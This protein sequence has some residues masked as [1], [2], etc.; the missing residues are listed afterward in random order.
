MLQ[1]TIV[2]DLDGT[3]ADTS[4]DLLAAANTALDRGGYEPSLTAA[5]HGRLAMRGA[6]AMLGAA[7]G[8]KHPDLD[9]LYPALIEAYA[10]RDH[11]DSRLYPGVERVI[12]RMAADGARMAVC[13][14]KRAD[15]AQQVL[16]KLG[17]RDHFRALIGRDSL[18]VCKPDPEPLREA[19]RRAGGD[20]AHAVMIGDTNTD[21]QA[22]RA[23]GVPCILVPFGAEVD[24]AALQPDM[25]M[26]H[27]DDL[28]GLLALLG[29]A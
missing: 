3:L 7:L 11:A 26:D 4:A 29:P 9:R 16:E 14:N 28:P 18:A 8:P 10:E 22:A 20:P 6:V 24:V 21:L 1:R 15:L 12:G 27:F 23:A 25:V 17:L 2:F 5:Q 19:V 13:T